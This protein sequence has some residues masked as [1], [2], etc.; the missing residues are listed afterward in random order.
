MTLEPSLKLGKDKW[1]VHEECLVI[2]ENGNRLLTTRCPK[3][4]LNIKVFK[5]VYNFR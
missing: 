4:C 1:I 2:T 5:N 3:K